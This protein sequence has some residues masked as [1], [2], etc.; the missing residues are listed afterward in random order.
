MSLLTRL[1]ERKAIVVSSFGAI[2]R[3]LGEEHYGVL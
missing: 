1:K 3:P 2:Q